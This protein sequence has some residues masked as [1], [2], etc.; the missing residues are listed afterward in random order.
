MFTFFNS[1]FVGLPIR[2]SHF[3]TI[4]GDFCYFVP[5]FSYSWH[6]ICINT[7]VCFQ[8]GFQ[9]RLQNNKFF[10][11]LAHTFSA[12][13]QKQI[14]AIKF[15]FSSYLFDTIDGG[16]ML[17][18]LSSMMGFIPYII[19]YLLQSL[20]VVKFRVGVFRNFLIHWV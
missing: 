19:V 13:Q 1:N 15:Y 4:P 6:I 20:Q 17:M 9:Y 12:N 8:H 16:Q 2:A 7:E 11:N 18:G 14:L 3:W 10:L 5:H